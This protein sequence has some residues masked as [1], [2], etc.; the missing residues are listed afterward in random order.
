MKP[1]VFAVI[2]FST[3]TMGARA[4]PSH[5]LCIVEQSVGFHWNNQTGKWTPE[6]FAPGAKYIFREL[7]S[8]DWNHNAGLRAETPKAT[9]GLF[10]VGGNDPN[11]ALAACTKYE[12]GFSC[13]PRVGSLTFEEGSLRFE[14]VH[15]GSYPGQ[16]YW[17]RL[18]RDDPATYA[19][20]RR[21]PASHPDDDFFEI[22]TCAPF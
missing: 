14:I 7:N 21:D 9:W 20:Q 4:A 15:S 18:Q 12:F 19:L 5:Y 6:T 11:L 16:G 13:S 22:G 3:V 1:L 2:G 8:S 10:E 17:K